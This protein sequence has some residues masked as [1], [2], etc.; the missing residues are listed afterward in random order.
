MGGSKLYIAFILLL[1][2][3]PSS[4]R[5]VLIHWESFFPQR[6]KYSFI[7]GQKAA[8]SQ[9]NAHLAVLIHADFCDHIIRLWFKHLYLFPLVL[10]EM[11][12]SQQHMNSHWKLFSPK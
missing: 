8:C 9:P 3:T 5:R 12:S 2:E 10:L 7:S 4:Q 1:L 6:Q 11:L